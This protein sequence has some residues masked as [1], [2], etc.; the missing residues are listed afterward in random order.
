MLGFE[1]NQKMLIICSVLS[2]HAVH[3]LNV[4]VPF[5]FSSAKY[6]VMKYIYGFCGGSRYVANAEYQ[7]WFLNQKILDWKL[8]ATLLWRSHNSSSFPSICTSAEHLVWWSIAEEENFQKVW[9]SSVV[10]TRR[11]SS[12]HHVPQTRVWSMLQQGGLYLYHMQHVQNLMPIVSSILIENRIIT[13]VLQQ[14]SVYLRQGPQQSHLTSLVRSESWWC[15]G[16]Q[17]SIS[18]RC[19]CIVWHA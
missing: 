5:T 8:L 19:K 13:I 18:V 15:C 10:G 7:P 12:H 17:F 6:I 1:L 16:K 4:I 3:V 11:T 14:K 2:Q 9:F